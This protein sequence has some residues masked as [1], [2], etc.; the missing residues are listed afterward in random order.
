MGFPQ[1]W[2]TEVRLLAW[3]GSCGAFLGCGQWA[4]WAASSQVS[5][6]ALVP[7]SRAPP[8]DLVSP[9]SQC[10]L[11]GEGGASTAQL[12]PP[13]HEPRSE[14]HLV[15]ARRLPGIAWVCDEP[16]PY[17][18]IRRPGAPVVCS[19][20][21]RFPGTAPCRLE[22]GSPGGWISFSTQA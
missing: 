16:H 15:L 1:S 13:G 11:M 14:C 10:P 22:S 9:A 19:T 6:R 3:S 20:V 17:R 21:W 12:P 8:G 5:L 7:L 4:W 2:G 18:G